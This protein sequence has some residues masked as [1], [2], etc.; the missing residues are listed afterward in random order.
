MAKKIYNQLDIIERVDK[1][2]AQ[3]ESE[4]DELLSKRLREILESLNMMYNKFVV[5]DKSSYTDL[6][7]YN[8]LS[9][10]LK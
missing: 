7:K 10:E 3:S 6:N 8:R 5:D 4:V 9:K 1:M 2:I